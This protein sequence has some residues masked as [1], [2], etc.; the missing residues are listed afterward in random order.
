MKIGYKASAEQFGPKELG[1]YA[2]LA[3]RLGLDSVMISDHFQPWRLTG[4][5][6]PSALGWMPWVLARTERVVVGTSVLTPTFRYNPPVIA[7]AFA[8]MGC[9]A[10][11]R[12][13]LGVGTGEAL[14]EIA[15]GSVAE[16]EWPAFKERFGR[17]REAVRLIRALWTEDEVTFEGDYYRTVGA[18]IYDRPDPL[19]AV[20]VAAGGPLVARYAGRVGDGFICT[21]GKGAALYS[22]ALLPAVAEG[23][24]KAGRSAAGI[25]RMIELKISYDRDAD[26]AAENCRFWAPLSLSAEQKH[27][28]ASPQEME[29]AADRLPLATVTKRWIATA[30]PA[31][32]VARVKEYTDLGFDHLV[33]HGP[34]HDQ[35]RFL[36]SFVEDVVPGLRELVPGKP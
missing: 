32:V 26:Q 30:D 27:S 31:E 23:R 13:M 3:E 9:L 1:E 29:A 28:I 24:Q 8:T 21:S 11:G 10:P 25:D 2:V 17:L 14:N 12:V 34:G 4:G 36:T 7:Q 35:E 6:A 19:P 16:G 33:V 18:R 22:D 15:V 20:Y 5:H